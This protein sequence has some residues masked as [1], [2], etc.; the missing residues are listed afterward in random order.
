MFRW[1]KEIWS[2]FLVGT[3]NI[4]PGVSGGTLLF[5]LGLYERTIS[6]LSKFKAGSVSALL[7]G[8][9]G[10]LFSNKRAENLR[11]F[12]EQAQALDIPFLIRLGAGAGAAIL[13]LSGLMMFLLET[14]FANTYAFFFGLIVLSTILS[15]KMV[16]VKKP[17]YLIHFIIGAAITVA[18]TAAFNPVNDAKEKSEH[19]RTV[20]EA[21]KAS[22]LSASGEA[23]ESAG[24]VKQRALLKYT[25]RYTGKELAI[26]AASGA[27]AVCAMI[28]PG[29]SGS[30][31]LVL[32]GRYYEV[33]SAVSGLKTL[34]LDYILY[35]TIFAAG[36]GIGL[37]AFARVIDL[38]FKRFY[39]DTIAFLIGLM[40]GS[41]YALWPFKKTV[42]MDLYE[43][44]VDGITLTQNAVVQTNINILPES[45]VSLLLA[46]LFCGVGAAIMI[47]LEKY[48]VEKNS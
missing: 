22:E 36:M 14:Q 23:V 33:I 44:G 27:I 9:W 34:Q 25:G 18:V 24:Q 11:L 28:L 37:L 8:A 5:L 20:S 46:L 32:M 30:L 3:A 4:I 1:I 17:L 48:N 21:A 39:D 16:K 41:L 15:V 31:V 6:A 47:V 26:A 29:L 35:L 2:G 40:A 7:R 19:Y 10:A 13:L 43:K 45:A 38:V 12:T 42:T